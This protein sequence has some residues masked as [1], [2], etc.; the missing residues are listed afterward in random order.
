[1]SEWT[2]SFRGTPSGGCIRAEWWTP[3]DLHALVAA[4]ARHGLIVEWGEALTISAPE[5]EIGLDITDATHTHSNTGWQI[6]DRYD[7]H[8]ESAL[9]R[10]LL[11]RT[12]DGV[13]YEMVWERKTFPGE[14]GPNTPLRALCFPIV[15]SPGLGALPA[16]RYPDALIADHEKEI[17]A[18]QA[19]IDKL[20]VRKAQTSCYYTVDGD[21]IPWGHHISP[22]GDIVP[23]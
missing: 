9:E 16:H 21:A 15:E 4:C 19:E 3:G 13:V 7:R 5:D 20:R 11:P 23:D 14:V 12:L 6:Y 1:M 10:R 2:K 8:S 22:D 17:A 18:L